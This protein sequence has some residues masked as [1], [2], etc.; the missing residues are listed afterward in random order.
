LFCSTNWHD[1][2]SRADFRAFPPPA[3]PCR[4][5]RPT[6]PGCDLQQDN[7]DHELQLP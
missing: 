4:T 2:G 3:A 7:P 5:R 6:T 1:H